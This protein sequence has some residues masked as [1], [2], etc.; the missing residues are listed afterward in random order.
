MLYYSTFNY[1]SLCIGV[2]IV[3]YIGLYM[4][5]ERVIVIRLGWRII[6]IEC[7]KL[8]KKSDAFVGTKC[9]WWMKRNGDVFFFKLM[10]EVKRMNDRTRKNLQIM[11]CVTF[12]ILSRENRPLKYETLR[13]MMEYEMNIGHWVDRHGIHQVKYQI[14]LFSRAIYIQNGTV[15]CLY[16]STGAFIFPRNKQ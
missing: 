11:K 1:I 7:Q 10:M 2:N 9:A 3:K 13:N 6:F 4:L 15:Y 8:Q 12:L 5:L 16:S 14:S